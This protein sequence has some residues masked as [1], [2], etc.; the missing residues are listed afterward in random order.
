M[1]ARARRCHA[2]LVLDRSRDIQARCAMIKRRCTHGTGGG[3][4]GFDI[5]RVK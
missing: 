3:E 2:Q 4:Q 1:P 5:E